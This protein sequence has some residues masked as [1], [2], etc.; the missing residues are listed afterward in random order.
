MLHNQRAYQL[1]LSK[2]ACPPLAYAVA[3]CARVAGRSAAVLSTLRSAPL[4]QEQLELLAQKAPSIYPKP[5]SCP[6]EP[7]ALPPQDPGVDVSV[8]VPVHNGERFL[9]TCLDSILAQKTRRTVQLLA[10]EDGSTD[11]SAV[12]LAEYAQRGQLTILHPAKGG[13]AARARNTGLLHVVGKWILFVDC[14]DVL[15]PDAIETLA[16]AMEHTHADIVQGGWQYL[17]EAGNKGARQQYAQTLYEGETRLDMLDLPGMPWGKLYRRELF[18][19]VRFPENYT[20]FEDAI[21]HFLVF[22]LAKRVASIKP[23]VYEWRKNT[24]GL[25]SAS[26]HTSKAMQAYWIAE[27]MVQQAQRLALPQDAL[28]A[29]N[30]LLQLSN[31]CY[32]CVAGFSEPELQTVFACCCT[33]FHQW[34]AHL[35]DVPLPYAAALAKRALSSNDYALWKLQ[36]R[37]FQLIN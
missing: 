30:L 23:I 27:E 13:S 17:D 11:A 18:E 4:P 32:A 36:G 5:A 34:E 6:G 28:F 25:T 20:C 15:C 16:N 24:S 37:L 10:V 2:T 22:P 12:I 19:R 26:Q 29:C 31:Y 1:I 33:L 35:P 9:R 21:L 7:P 8:I 14:D 3:G